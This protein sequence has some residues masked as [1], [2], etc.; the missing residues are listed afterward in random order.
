MRRIL[1]PIRT[2]ISEAFG[3]GSAPAVA[4]A[5]FW[6]FATGG[7]LGLVSTALP[8]ERPRTTAAVVVTSVLA[9]ALSLVPGIGFRRLRPVAYELLCAAGTLLVSAGLYFGGT[10]AYEF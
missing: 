10:S 2:T 7:V 4:R 1:P 6:L 9:L 8:S 5:S 3:A